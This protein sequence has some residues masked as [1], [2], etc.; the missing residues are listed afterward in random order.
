MSLADIWAP[1]SPHVGGSEPRGALPLLRVAVR[2]REAGRLRGTHQLTP[3]FYVTVSFGNCF[4]KQV[5]FLKNIV[6]IEFFTCNIINTYES[7]EFVCKGFHW[8]E[9]YRS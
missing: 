1:G 6:Y 3:F 5:F 7:L 8:L 2:S 4:L 9:T